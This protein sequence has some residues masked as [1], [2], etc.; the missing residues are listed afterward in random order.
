MTT[1]R[2]ESLRAPCLDAS[3]TL[4]TSTSERRILSVFL[5]FRWLGRSACCASGDLSAQYERRRIAIAIISLVCIVEI[6]N[7]FP[8]RLSTQH[9]QLHCLPP[10]ILLL[11]HLSASAAG[12]VA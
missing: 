1:K 2:V 11:G 10:L 8:I 5:S 6:V 4:A 7:K 9:L 3:S 12:R